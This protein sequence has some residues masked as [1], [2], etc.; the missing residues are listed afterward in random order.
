MNQLYTWYEIDKDIQD[1]LLA[2]I[3]Y[4]YTKIGKHYHLAGLREYEKTYYT[5]QELIENVDIL[6][7][8]QKNEVWFR[9]DLEVISKEKAKFWTTPN[10]TCL[11]DIIYYTEPE[12]FKKELVK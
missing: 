1:K 8:K 4:G 11:E 6:F 9:E 10:P 3:T 2:V 5:Q 12:H 7:D